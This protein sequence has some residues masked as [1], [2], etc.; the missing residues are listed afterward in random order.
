[1]VHLVVVVVVDIYLFV[2]IVNCVN[3]HFSGC[4]GQSLFYFIRSKKRKKKGLNMTAPGI[5]FTLKKKRFFIINIFAFAHQL[6]CDVVN[7]FTD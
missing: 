6:L 5:P 3:I 7:P 4:I 1:M 2:H